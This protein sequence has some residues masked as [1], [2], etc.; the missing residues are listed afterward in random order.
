MTKQRDNTTT[1]RLLVLAA[2]LLAVLPACR[3][4]RS[5]KPPIHFNPNMD[6]V[7]RVEAQEPAAFFADGRGMRP[8]VEGT[9]ARG[10]LR[11]DTHLYAGQDASGAWVDA[12]PAALTLSHDFVDRG[13]ARY[14]IYCTPCHG[15]AGLEN[16]GVVPQRAALGGTAWAIPSLH[17]PRQ[18]GYAIGQLFDVIT[19]GFNT[20][21]GYAAQIPVEDRWAI[22]TYVRALQVSYEMPLAQLPSEIKAEQGWR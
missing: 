8:Q 9:V 11:A 5:H 6:N 17:G 10:E 15:D 22:A 4:M 13:R 1:V 2:L 3:G 12:L 16:G 14:G 20:M 18:R 21:P 19:N 7:S